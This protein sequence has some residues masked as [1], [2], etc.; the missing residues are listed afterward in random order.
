MRVASLV[1]LAASL[2][3]TAEAAKKAAKIT[4]KVFFEVEHDGVPL[5][6]IEFGLFGKTTPKT[7]ENFRALCTGEK[8]KPR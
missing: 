7:V 3:I 8:G 2:A 1:A 5:G 4:H 6:R